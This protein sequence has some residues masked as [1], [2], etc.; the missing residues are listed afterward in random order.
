VPKKKERDIV[1]SQKSNADDDYR[2]LTGRPIKGELEPPHL[3]TEH[4]LRWQ[5]RLPFHARA[6]PSNGA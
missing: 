1:D 4:R 3:S 2:N 5:G 6:H